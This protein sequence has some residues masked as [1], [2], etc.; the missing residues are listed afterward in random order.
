MT[1]HEGWVVAKEENNATKGVC[2]GSCWGMLAEVPENT[3]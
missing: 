1:A 3:A 2:L